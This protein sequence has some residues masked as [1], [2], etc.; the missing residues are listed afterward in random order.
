MSSLDGRIGL[1]RGLGSRAVSL[2]PRMDDDSAGLRLRKATVPG[3]NSPS[4]TRL[5]LP[6][7]LVGLDGSRIGVPI[8][9]Y[10]TSWSGSSRSAGE[11]RSSSQSEP[12]M[13]SYLG[14][15]WQ[16]EKEVGQEIC[17]TGDPASCLSDEDKYDGMCCYWEIIGKLCI[18]ASPRGVGISYQHSSGRRV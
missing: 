9:S 13:L 4:A 8:S 12:D 14:T 5:S 6:L 3:V 15:R 10:I 11:S 17:R 18:P 16:V 1:G 7:L 2:G